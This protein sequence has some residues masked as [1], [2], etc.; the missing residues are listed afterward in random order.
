MNVE[1]NQMGYY[2]G[3]IKPT[4]P[5]WAAFVEEFN[6]LMED[7]TEFVSDFRINLSE[8]DVELKPSSVAALENCGLL[9]DA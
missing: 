6:E 5:N 2:G 4:S 7:D 1:L 8:I 9:E 3:Q